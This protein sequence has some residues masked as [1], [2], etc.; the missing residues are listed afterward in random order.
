MGKLVWSLGL[1]ALIFTCSSKKELKHDGF[2]AGVSLGTIDNRQIN[3]ASGLAASR[4]YVNKF[5]THNDSGDQPRIFLIDNQARHKATLYLKNAF[6]RDWEDIA[7]GPGPDENK[8]YIYVGEIGDNLGVFR[9]KCIYR[10]V[11]PDIRQDTVVTDTIRTG[12]EPIKF[13]L[14]DGAR[15]TEALMVDPLTKDI[16]LFSK[17]EENEI[18]LYRLAY[19]QPTDGSAVAKFLIHIPITQVVSADI[20]PD[21]SEVLVKNY[22]N[23]YYW[24]RHSQESIEA[25]LQTKPDTLPYLEEPQGEAIAFDVEGKGYYTLS[26]EA[27]KVRPQLMF[28]RRKRAH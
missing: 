13:Q 12:I 14:S 25:L 4:K 5:W 27:R 17:R 22:E 11:E 15:D 9:N 20:S 3:E 6:H 23:V 2:E 26:E 28:Y 7:V 18:N 16:Y 19:P 10:I 1:V 21:G 24:K 8:N